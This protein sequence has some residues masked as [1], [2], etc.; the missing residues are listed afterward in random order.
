M[1]TSFEC[2][3][4]IGMK[5]HG[6][7]CASMGA[8]EPG[9][10]AVEDPE[11]YAG[12]APCPHCFESSGYAARIIPDSWWEPGWAEPDPLSP[13]PYCEGTGYV[14]CDLVTLEDLE[15]EDLEVS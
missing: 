9:G 13:C 1:G 6:C 10:H 14:E 2:K 3:D 12:H 5:E 7:Y 4:C 8:S 15:N 11:P